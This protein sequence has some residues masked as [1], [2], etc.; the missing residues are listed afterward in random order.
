MQCHRNRCDGCDG[1]GSWNVQL[2]TGQVIVDKTGPRNPAGDLAGSVLSLDHAVRN[3]MAVTLCSVADAVAVSSTS[4]AR[5]IGDPTRGKLEAGVRGDVVLVDADF[6][7][8]ATI[9]GGV[10]AFAVSD[11]AVTSSR[12]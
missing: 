9:V 12:S 4:A 6:N 8:K 11:V 2:G 3:F 5:A 10:V 1:H 7:V